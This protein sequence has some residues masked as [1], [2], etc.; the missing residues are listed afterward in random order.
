M[1]TTDDIQKYLLCH[2]FFQTLLHYL[3]ITSP[4]NVCGIVYE[5]NHL[6]KVGASNVERGVLA[7][8][9]G[10][11]RAPIMGVSAEPPA[12]FRG[13]APGQEVRGGEAHPEAEDILSFRSANQMQICPFFLSCMLLK[14][15]G[16]F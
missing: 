3:L 10:L 7:Y 11:S 8:N 16:S 15:T 12:G 5:W 9:G 1:C 14:Y 6:R 2:C 4:E 13:R